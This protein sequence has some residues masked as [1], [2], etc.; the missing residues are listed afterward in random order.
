MNFD[1]LGVDRQLISGVFRSAY[2]LLLLFQALPV[3]WNSKLTRHFSGGSNRFGKGRMGESV[4]AKVQSTKSSHIPDLKTTEFRLGVLNGTVG[5][6]KVLA[7][8][9]SRCTVSC[10][11]RKVS[12]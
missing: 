2:T 4:G 12:G 10:E 11:R 9:Q 8:S 1:A 6:L 7:L 3:S 5:Q